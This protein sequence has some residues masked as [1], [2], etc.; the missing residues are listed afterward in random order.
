MENK[1]SFILYC[2]L[3]HTVEKLNDTDAGELFKHLLRYVNDQNPETLNPI[4]DIVF[5]PIKQA[6]KRDLKKW[7]NTTKGRSEAGMKSAGVKE[8]RKDLEEKLLIPEFVKMSVEEM[9]FER[10]RCI[11]YKN[12]N[13]GTYQ[14]YY[15]EEWVKWYEQKLTN[16][17]NVDSVQ[18]VSTNSTDNV[19]VNDSVNVNDNVNVIVSKGNLKKFQKPTLLEISDYCFER[20]NK[21]NPEKFHDFYESNGWKVGKNSMKDWK[22]AIRN[23]EKNEKTP[24][25]SGQPPQNSFEKSMKAIEEM[26]L[27]NGQTTYVP[28]NKEL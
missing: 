10:S 25:S 22:A 17:T 1:K 28:T 2:D 26:G 3:I 5:E 6:F 27:L 7:E 20:N 15:Y 23:W 13:Y 12:E 8:F 21:V 18:Q 11:K 14:H 4:V 24:P 16:S 9:M 19:S